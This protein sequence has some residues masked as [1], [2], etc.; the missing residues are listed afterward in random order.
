MHVHVMRMHTLG[1]IGESADNLARP[2]VQASCAAYMHNS[3]S[4]TREQFLDMATALTHKCS[5]FDVLD[6]ATMKVKSGRAC[7]QQVLGCCWGQLPLLG[8]LSCSRA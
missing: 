3:L 4:E 7:R 2:A 8:V 1:C 6:T 5:L